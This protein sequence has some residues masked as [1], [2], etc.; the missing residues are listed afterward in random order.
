MKKIYLLG[1]LA[2]IMTTFSFGQDFKPLIEK[3]WKNSAELRAKNFLL[4]QAEFALQ[5]AKAMYGPTVNL[6][7]QYTLA[8]GGRTIAFPI[9]DLLNPVHST[10]NTLTQS[11]QFP[12]LENQNIQFF[13][14]N[15]YDARLRVQQPIFYPDLAINRAVKEESIHLQALDI[16]AYKRLLSKEVMQAYFTWQTAQ[17]ALLIFSSADS[18]LSTGRRT[19]EILLRE[20]LALPSALA[21]I[22]A[23][24]ASLEAQ[25]LNTWNQKNNARDY[26][27]Y[28]CGDTSW[29]VANLP[30]LPSPQETT[31]SGRE[32][33]AL[34]DQSIKLH[35]LALK[36]ETLFYKPRLGALLDLGS[37]DFNFGWQ[38]YA[39]LGL[40]LEINLYDH[41]RHQYKTE[42]AKIALQVQ[43]E[44]KEHVSRQLQLATQISANNLAASIAQAEAQHAR[45]LLAQRVYKDIWR[46]YQEGTANYLE[47]V[48]AQ[49]QITTAQLQYNL[50]RFGAW[51][52]WSE[53]Y[54]N[55]ASLVIQ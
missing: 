30:A 36:K 44:K 26:L 2:S 20:G 52:M 28:L 23:E 12:V 40:N 33:I 31:S 19:T 38:P 16:K 21:R 51:T 18:L 14:N 9:G 24:K 47:L 37:Q 54:Y 25:R 45:A 5:E 27:F 4:S 35:E 10:L 39:L 17:E 43:T 7:T 41:R 53:D 55:R 6:G 42:Q 13:P 49:N 48:D 22:D 29:Q 15:F 50:A 46:K 32:E 1:L 3:T 8:Q 11:N 34:L